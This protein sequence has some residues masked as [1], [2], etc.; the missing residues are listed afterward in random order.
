MGAELFVQ[1]H[2]GGVLL[3][4]ILFVTDEMYPEMAARSSDCRALV[5]VW[6]SL[7]LNTHQLYD[8]VWFPGRCRQICDKNN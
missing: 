4:A 6:R 8:R 3:S 1:G 7:F 5:I 2:H